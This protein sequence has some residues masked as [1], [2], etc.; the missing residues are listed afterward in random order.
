MRPEFPRKTLIL[1]VIICLVTAGPVFA[2][3]TAAA[4][5]A[6]SV[7]FSAEEDSGF[8][9][10]DETGALIRDTA[11]LDAVK[12]GWIIQTDTTKVELHVDGI[13]TIILSPG[14]FLSFDTIAPDHA[15]ILLLWGKLRYLA[16]ST[17]YAV[18]FETP[19]AEYSISVVGEY[20][21][22]SEAS[23]QFYTISGEAAVENRVSGKVATIG[24]SQLFEPLNRRTPEKEFDAQAAAEL[25][26]TLP[27]T[28]FNP[29]V[30]AA[31]SPET[32]SPPLDLLL[33]RLSILR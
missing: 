2:D 25:K 6:L 26:N 29:L 18:M 15:E 27:F 4:N 10:F 31:T 7:Q 21:L 5:G 9:I 12:E 32:E 16:A 20:V 33:R 17:T 22:I 13:G 1:A 30:A 8:W 28:L 3:D 11:A 23:E 14:S 19:T 24:S